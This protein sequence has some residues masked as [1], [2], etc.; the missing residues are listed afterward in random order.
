MLDTQPEKLIDCAARGL[1]FFHRLFEATPSFRHRPFVEVEGC[2]DFVPVN[3]F[4]HQYQYLGIL[5]LHGE[6][7]KTHCRRAIVSK[8]KIQELD[9]LFFSRHCDFSCFAKD[10][11]LIDLYWGTMTEVVAAV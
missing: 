5:R 11:I 7:S 3:L 8:D 4:I 9:V 10:A 1:A 2:A 6:W